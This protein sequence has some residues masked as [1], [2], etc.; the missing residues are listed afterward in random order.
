MTVAAWS[1]AFVVGA[2]LAFAGA[3][4]LAQ[5]RPEQARPATAARPSAQKARPAPVKLPAA[6]E[7][8]FTK[9]YPQAQIKNVSHETEEGVEQYEIESINSGLG[10][11][12][13]YK[14]DGTLLVVEEEVRAADVPAAV[15]A[16]ITARYPQ[17]KIVRPERATER[18][19]ISYEISVKG[20]PVKSVQLTPEGK[21]IS[22]K[23]GK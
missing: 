20:A 3:A 14:P 21:W 10:L 5:A 7:A 2:V 17:A 6:V 9:A 15:M 22:P 16:A 19:T 23:P 1:R 11:D 18:G 8:A 4:I 13:N 12:V